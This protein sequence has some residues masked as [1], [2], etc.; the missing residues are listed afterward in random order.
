MNK[1]LIVATAGVAV[2]AVLGGIFG[3]RNGRIAPTVDNAAGM[4]AL[5]QASASGA[6]RAA[7]GSI[8]QTVSRLQEHLT[9]VP[10][11]YPAWASLG[12]AYVQQAK[13]TV[14]S[15][16][17]PKAQGALDTSLAIN[18]DDNF[19]AYAGLSALASAQHDFGAAES[20]AR[21]GL[22]RNAS[23]PVLYGAL[24][25]AL[26]QLGRYN[27]ADDAITKMASLRPDTS[28]FSRQ[29]Y[30][31]E[32][33]GDTAGARTLMQ[34][35]LNVAPTPADKAFALFYLGELLFNAGDA[36]AA[37][38]NYREALAA[39]PTDIQALAGKAKAE[40]ALGQ[41]LTAIDDYTAVVA[42]AP[43]P[44]LVLEFGEFLQSIG[45]V[46]DAKAQY[47]VVEATQRLFET[48]GVEPDATP[49]LFAADHGTPAAA[50][51]NAEKGIT[52]RPFVVMQDAYAWALHVNGRDAEALAAL[53]PALQLGTRSALMRYHAGMIHLSLG[54]RDLAQAE[55]T[56]ALAINP[57][58]HPLA[59]P[60]AMQTLNTLGPVT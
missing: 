11:D 39:S 2:L 12:L 13:L 15:D 10:K 27:E 19:L 54:R 44:G 3:V 22:A 24:G 21:K 46:A 45:R 28:S 50:L 30:L 31:R 33:R 41:H 14:N 55:L 6:S 58:F 48:N 53:Q 5:S 59:A 4:S 40:A 17:Y 60:I 51:A 35:A 23:S 32:L 18:D 38:D 47:D 37:L 49:T 8:D 29:S 36:N 42:R 20:F 34:Q 16:Y 26:V 7:D 57:F 52:T 1:R 56:T 9:R 43:E 25:D